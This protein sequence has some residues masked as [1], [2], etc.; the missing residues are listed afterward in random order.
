MAPGSRWSCQWRV[1]RWPDWWSNWKSW[2]HLPQE[3]VSKAGTP[4]SLSQQHAPQTSCLPPV[5]IG[6]TL[7]TPSYKRSRWDEGWSNLSVF[8]ILGLQVPGRKHITLPG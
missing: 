6:L 2:R 5:R 1:G 8:L 3:P 4:E 7:G